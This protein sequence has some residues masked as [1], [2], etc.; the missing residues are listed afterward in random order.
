MSELRGGVAGALIVL[1]LGVTAPAGATLGPG[2]AVDPEVLGQTGTSTCG[3][4]NQAECGLQ[5]AT[6]QGAWDSDQT[7]DDGFRDP[8]TYGGSCW[9]CPDDYIRSLKPVT[10][11]AACWR[12][13]HPEYA[14]AIRKTS[15]TGYWPHE[16]WAMGAFWDGIHGGT[17]WTCPEAYP[18]RG[19]ASVESDEACWR[20]SGHQEARAELIEVLGCPSKTAGQL[21]PDGNPFY[22]PREGG[23]CWTCPAFSD[24][25]VFAVDSDQACSVG[26]GWTSPKYK[27]PGLF[28]L[29]GAKD[30]IV[31]LLQH[32]QDVTDYLYVLAK[33]G[34]VPPEDRATWVAARWAEIGATPESSDAINS[35]ANLKV[36]EAVE[37]FDMLADDA[38]KKRLALAFAQYVRDRRT[39]VAEDALHMYDVWKAGND[40]RRSQRPPNIG[41]LFYIGTPPPDFLRH[42]QDEW[43]RL[44]AGASVGLGMVGAAAAAAVFSAV[45]PQS[46]W[47]VAAFTD[48]PV[49]GVALAFSQASAAITGGA[50][51]AEGVIATAGAAMAGASIIAAVGVAIGAAAI[52]IVVKSE[53]ARPTLVDN[54]DSAKAAV[55]ITEFVQ[56]SKAFSY[57]WTLGTSGPSAYCVLPA[58][59]ITIVSFECGGYAVAVGTVRTTANTALQIAQVGGFT[60]SF[61]TFPKITSAAKTTFAGN[62]AGSFT[63]TTSGTTPKI[64]LTGD[65]PSGVKFTDNKDGTAT[66]SG[67]PAA[68]AQGVYA[69]TLKAANDIGAAT[70]SFTLTIGTPPSFTSVPA[71]VFTEGL[72]STF[73]IKATGDPT[74]ELD[75]FDVP[76]IIICNANGECAA[77]LAGEGHLP[78]GVSFVDNGDG[79][80]TISGK[81][82]VG[83]SDGGLFPFGGRLAARNLVATETKDVTITVQ[84]PPLTGLGPAR[85]WVGLKNSDSIGLRVDLLAEVLLKVGSSETV[86]ATGQL[87]NQ[88][89]GGSGFN[90]AVL[91][92]IPLTLKNPPVLV[93]AGS[94]LE[95]RVSARRTCSGGGHN[96]GTVLLWYNGAIKDSGNDRDAGSRFDAKRGERTTLSTFALK[97][98]LTLSE[99]AGAAKTSTAV[100]VT[101]TA[102]CT[103]TAGRPFVSF[104]KWAAPIR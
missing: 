93:P 33:Q 103:T 94:Q 55:D 20:D 59:P 43:L 96:T 87:D 39:F 37:E 17:C 73:T 4:P 79:T 31:G 64:T 7:C 104:G 71:F 3:G 1:L 32:P 92:T 42:S 78:D 62:V 85:V 24:R 100:S 10:D 63:V 40:Y 76:S 52:D 27:E 19:T 75:L 70:Q 15:S 11:P 61:A 53:T 46:I 13:A 98:S 49:G 68:N 81:P 66:I 22:D 35:M 80:A 38:P 88:S 47:S 29:D 48:A 57:Y 50:Q 86:I 65:L 90:N 14:S 9:K 23:E 60:P 89:T 102:S 28:G 30:V 6:K 16:C 51:A 84:P 91:N 25:T 99:T 21:Y 74:P 36:L 2:P 101:S 56:D 45:I 77:P 95:F 67:T 72:S 26:F 8:L 12:A 58:G 54:L 69:V 97:P 34:N 41:D 44:T 83:T 82:G 18:A 5:R